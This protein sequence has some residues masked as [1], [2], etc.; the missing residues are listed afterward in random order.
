MFRHLFTTALGTMDSRAACEA[1]IK[2]Q[3]VGLQLLHKHT[4]TTAHSS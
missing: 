4:H 3:G 1:I 2:Q